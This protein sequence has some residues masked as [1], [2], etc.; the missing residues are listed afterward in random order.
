MI[1]SKFKVKILNEKWNCYVE[2]LE[3]KGRKSAYPSMVV[4]FCLDIQNLNEAEYHIKFGKYM[5]SNI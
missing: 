5:V 1:I 2:A 4:N 3:T